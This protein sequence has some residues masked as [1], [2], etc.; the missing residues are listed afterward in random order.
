MPLL[1][2]NG[3]SFIFLSFDK[4]NNFVNTTRFIVYKEGP[5]I[6][7]IEPKVL[8]VNQEQTI[9]VTGR[10]FNPSMKSARFGKL[11]T[12]FV[13]MSSSQIKVYVPIIATSEDFSNDFKLETS[14]EGLFSN[15]ISL[16]FCSELQI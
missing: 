16:V 9:L 4:G 14:S 12:N 15:S 1:I 5:F 8:L 11:K 2:K 13:Y 10:N 7:S 3:L 6:Y